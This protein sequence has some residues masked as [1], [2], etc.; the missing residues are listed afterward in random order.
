M[1]ARLNSENRGVFEV[2]DNNTGG[3]NKFPSGR[4]LE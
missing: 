3:Q 1:Q 2:V 4:R